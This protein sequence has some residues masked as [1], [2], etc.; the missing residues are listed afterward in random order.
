M[1]LRLFLKQERFRLLHRERIISDEISKMP[2]G[3][4]QFNRNGR[5]WKWKRIVLNDR[6]KEAGMIIPK[7]NPELA[8]VLTR[9]TVLQSALQTIDQQILTIDRF[10]A[11]Y[12]GAST[13]TVFPAL[14][15]A[16]QIKNLLPSLSERQKR[17]DDWD[18]MSYTQNPEYPEGRRVPT[19]AGF[20]VRS[21]S[22]AAIADTLFD[23]GIHFHYEQPL[24]VG[25]LTLY[26][27]FLI[28]DPSTLVQTVPWEHFGMIDQPHY[29]VSAK[30]KLSAYIDAGYYPGINLITSFETKDK[31]LDINL[32]CLLVG[33]FFSSSCDPLFN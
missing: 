9:K 28:L 20:L 1:N 24:K 7:S 23:E 6:G 26:P 33:Y 5:S 14:P 31:P 19:K 10:L 3:R 12:P 27:D 22:E 18:S 17:L 15:Y 29:A 13:Q 8:Q 21:K 16:D 25:E 2:E 11:D 4:I 30:A 32:I